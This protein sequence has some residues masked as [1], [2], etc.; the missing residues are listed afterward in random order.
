MKTTENRPIVVFN[1]NVTPTT[2]SN[3]IP[4]DFDG[5]V[6][7]NGIVDNPNLT[8]NASL[9]LKLGN[10]SLWVKD[11]IYVQNEINVYGNVYCDGS[12]V[13]GD[14][15]KVDGFLYSELG[16]NSFDVSVSQGL[17]SNGKLNIAD[18]A[19]GGDLEADTLTESI[20]LCEIVGKIILRKGLKF[21]NY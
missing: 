9:N 21:D 15:V 16:I 19:I 10:G 5:D 7:I 11:G 12:I 2:L 17:S 18:L 20:A 8:E 1:S 13:A 6:V 14:H 4:K 3:A